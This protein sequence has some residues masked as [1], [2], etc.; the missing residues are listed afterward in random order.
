MDF[1]DGKENK[2]NQGF[3]TGDH[4]GPRVLMFR[5]SLFAYLCGLIV[6]VLPYPVWAQTKL[7]TTAKQVADELT[8]V[9]KAIAEAY[10]S[11]SDST[12]YEFDAL[13]HHVET[14]AAAQ[15]SMAQNM[16]QSWWECFGFGPLN[17]TRFCCQTLME[18]LDHDLDRLPP[19]L[20]AIGESQNQSSAEDKAE[21]ARLGK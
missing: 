18:T 13:V 5:Q 4:S 19:V 15:G 17:S 1:L 14:L 21:H 7:T 20:S 11:N 9:W 10:W 3:S 6:A 2:H 12:V 16:A 8:V